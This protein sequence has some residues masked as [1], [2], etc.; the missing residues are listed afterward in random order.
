MQSYL[1]RR[2]HLSHGAAGI[3]A[4]FSEAWLGEHDADEIWSSILSVIAA[5]ISEEKHCSRKQIEAIGITNQRETTVVWDKHT[6]NP[7]YHAIV[8]QSRQT[9]DI[10]EELKAAWTSWN[11]FRR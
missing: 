11:V 8:W 9:A 2:E 6:G 4:V 1:I 10:C 5:V 3:Y 7:V